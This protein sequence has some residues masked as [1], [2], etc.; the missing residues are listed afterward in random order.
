MGKGIA[1]QTILLMLIGIVVVGILIY[2][3]YRT[4][5]NP[6]L[7]EEDCRARWI[8]QCTICKNSGWLGYTIP[9]EL[10]DCAKGTTLAFFSDNADC[11]R[12]QWYNT[13]GDC[14]TIGIE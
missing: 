13:E 14:K 3:V 9:Q 11:Q 4:V 5:M 12:G 10:R 7:S 1:T 8:S 2:I 6:T